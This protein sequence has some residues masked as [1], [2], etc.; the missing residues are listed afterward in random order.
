M[1]TLMNMVIRLFHRDINW[2]GTFRKATRLSVSSILK[3]E[4]EQVTQNVLVLS[5]AMHLRNVVVDHKLAIFINS[6]FE[7]RFTSSYCH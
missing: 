4:L 3:D 2:P 7:V 1:V 5:K 6:N